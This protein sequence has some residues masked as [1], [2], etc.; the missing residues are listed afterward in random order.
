VNLVCEGV[1][2]RRYPLEFLG[3]AAGPVAIDSHLVITSSREI[4]RD[5]C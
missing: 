2:D 4:L 1:S 3:G 5:I